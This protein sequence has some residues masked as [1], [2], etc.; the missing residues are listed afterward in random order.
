MAP[1][2]SS[3][4]SVSAKTFLRQTVPAPN[5]SHEAVHVLKSYGVSEEAFLATFADPT[6]ASLTRSRG[7]LQPRRQVITAWKYISMEIKTP[8]GL[9][10]FLF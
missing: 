2:Q 3:A 10:V 9:R 7:G 5:R 1:K 4:K 6:P 8:L